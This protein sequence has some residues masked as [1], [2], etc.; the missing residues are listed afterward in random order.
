MKQKLISLTVLLFI[1][2]TSVLAQ[3]VRGVET[4]RSIYNG[5]SYEVYVASARAYNIGRKHSN[6]TEYIGFE[7][8][9]LNSISVSVSI[10]VYRKGTNQLIDS[11]EIVLKPSE[12]YIHKYPK[13]EL[14]CSHKNLGYVNDL[15]EAEKY[16]KAEAENYYVKYRAFKLQ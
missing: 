12:S 7:F 5:E 4:K 6:H 16:G 11:K 15:E 14:Y 8:K 1:S 10:E 3:E 13:L 2:L 9:N